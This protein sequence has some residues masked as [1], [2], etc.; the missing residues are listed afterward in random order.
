MKALTC[1]ESDH[2]QNKTEQINTENLNE[3]FSKSSGN[4]AIVNS[5]DVPI[6]N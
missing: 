4:F 3:T 2:F 1:Y 5:L 6:Y